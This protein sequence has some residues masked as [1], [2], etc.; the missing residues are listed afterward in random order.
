MRHSTNSSGRRWRRSA[1]ALILAVTS[2]A[3][4]GV[5]RAQADAGNPILGTI[6]GTIVDNS[7]GSVDVYV[8]GQW[9]WLTHN[10]DCN[11]DRA[12]TGVG[13]IWND[14]KGSGYLVAKG[15]VSA[16]VGVKTPSAGNVQDQMVHPVD[17]GNVPEGYTAG[18][19]KSTTQGYSTN[20]PGDYP[21]GQIVADPSPNPNN[22]A[23]WKGGCGREPLSSTTQTGTGT[24]PCGTHV[25]NDS[26]CANH[27]WGSWGYDSS[28]NGGKGYKHH[29]ASRDDVSN[30]CAN[31][32]D[33]HGGGK[34]NS[35]KF[36]LVNGAKEIT[37]NGNADNSIQTNAF[38]AA[39]GANCITFPKPA[40]P[41][42]VTHA[43]GPVTIGNAI[44]DTA[45]MSNLNGDAGSITFKAYAPHADGTV[46]T[47]CTATPVL[48]KVVTGVNADGDYGSGDF[49]PTGTA[50]PAGT[51]P[52][53]AGTYQWVA[54]YQSGDTTKPP[55]ATL[56]TD[57]AEQSV[58]KRSP[59]AVPTAQSVVIADYGQVAA[60][61]LP[62]TP[63]PTGTVDFQ[64]FK[65][66]S[67]CTGTPL[68]DSG[69]ITLA[70]DGTANT[71]SA[72]AQPP[73]LTNGTYLWLITYS[74]DGTYA[75]STEPCGTEQ[76]TISDS[77]PG[78]GP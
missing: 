70:A 63:V 56:C 77:T 52:Q 64:L 28:I 11:F 42:I 10:S 31:F 15:S 25:A 33:V 39:N 16:E 71:H 60:K 12:G 9:N 22:Y 59:S 61:N 29:Y 78:I 3:M 40:A 2:V 17:V 18:T 69:Q 5:E 13:I 44:H 50:S 65:A 58:V 76:T 54:T 30:V 45:T 38:N 26:S 67:D 48:T 6:K 20:F 62:A 14:P 1:L 23:S 8:Q 72:A 37:V 4:F 75:K 19:W 27:P 68:W 66:P 74:G 34:F 49:V 7:D 24:N 57:T 46:D 53:I 36:Q 73:K 41:T 55:V 47:S 21:S 51:P 43:S 35:G 32:Y